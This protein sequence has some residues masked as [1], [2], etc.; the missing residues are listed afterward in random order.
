MHPRIF[1][2]ITA[3]LLGALGLGAVA[4][5]QWTPA[6]APGAPRRPPAAGGGPRAGAAPAP[7]PP[8]RARAG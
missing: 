6:A 8:P 2:I 7:P 1:A 4:V 5:T 3:F